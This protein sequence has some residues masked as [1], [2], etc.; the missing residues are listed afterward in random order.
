MLLPPPPSPHRAGYQR[1]GSNA[2]RPKTEA[3]I[4]CDNLTQVRKRSHFTPPCLDKVFL[5]CAKLLLF[6][7]TYIATDESKELI[8]SA[9]W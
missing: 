1:Q 2:K 5:L 4:R 3:E 8:S 7:C 9:R 6:L